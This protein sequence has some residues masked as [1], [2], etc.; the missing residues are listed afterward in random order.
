[1]RLVWT[2]ILG[3]VL[4]GCQAK[5]TGSIRI[6][7]RFV[8]PWSESSGKVFQMQ[9]NGW[10]NNIND[11]SRVCSAHAYAIHPRFR[12]LSGGHSLRGEHSA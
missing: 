2:T 1:M 6:R 12:L 4:V 3:L 9:Q 8:I 5:K 7:P 10:I 11:P